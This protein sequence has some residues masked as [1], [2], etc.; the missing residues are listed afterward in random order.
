M[1]VQIT[2]LW[3]RN[4]SFTM[5]PTSQCLLLL[6]LSISH[7]PIFSHFFLSVYI[8]IFSPISVLSSPHQW[9]SFTHSAISVLMQLGA[10]QVWRPGQVIT[11]ALLKPLASINWPS[12]IH[13]L[14]FFCSFHRHL[15]VQYLLFH[16]HRMSYCHLLCFEHCPNVISKIKWSYLF[17]CCSFSSY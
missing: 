1:N 5:W 3:P 11:F 9:H 7:H 16:V 2:K 6:Y 15:M 13:F 10:R 8:Y 12:F 17:I 14:S 4:T